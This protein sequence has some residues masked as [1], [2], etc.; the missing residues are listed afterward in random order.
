MRSYLK[1]IKKTITK[2]VQN[3]LKVQGLSTTKTTRKK[4]KANK[5]NAILSSDSQPNKFREGGTAL[6]QGLGSLALRLVPHSW[7]TCQLFG[8]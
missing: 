1:Q 3:R 4:K 5:P 6:S 8:T 2:R 7:C